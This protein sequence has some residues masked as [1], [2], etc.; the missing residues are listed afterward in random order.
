MIQTVTIDRTA[1][2]PEFGTSTQRMVPWLGQTD[3]PPFGQMAV[4]LDPGAQTAPDCHNQD[5]LVVVLSGRAEVRMDGESVPV[6]AGEMAFLPRN[7]T[8]V[9]ANPADE[10]LVWISIYWPLREPA[11][12]GEPGEEQHGA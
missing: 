5:E 7:H 11:I 6:S 9:V 12:T 1:A 8:H 10:E 3:E 2:K 4:F